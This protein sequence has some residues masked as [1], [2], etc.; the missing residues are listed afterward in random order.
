MA[1]SGLSNPMS[2]RAREI[3]IQSTY[4]SIGDVVLVVVAA[5]AVSMK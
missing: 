4:Y 1:E 5:A 2:N 3:V